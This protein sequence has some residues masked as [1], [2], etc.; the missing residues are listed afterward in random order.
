MLQATGN[1]KDM[2]I[3]AWSTFEGISYISMFLGFGLSFINY[4]MF[5]CF[6]A[7]AFL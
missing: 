4:F 3:M 2:K 7:Q 5:L 6:W 1:L